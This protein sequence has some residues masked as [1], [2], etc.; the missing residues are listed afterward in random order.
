MSFLKDAFSGLGK[1]PM[2]LLFLIFVVYIIIVPILS[3]FM[4][5]WFV[6]IIVTVIL[7]LGWIAVKTVYKDQNKVGRGRLTN[8]P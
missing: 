2:V 4:D 7:V 5:F 1:E 8:V 3:F 6:L